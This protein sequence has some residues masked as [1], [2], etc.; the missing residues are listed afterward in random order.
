MAHTFALLGFDPR[1]PFAAFTHSSELVYLPFL[2]P[3]LAVIAIARL[4]SRASGPAPLTPA[5][6]RS[7]R[8]DL[9]MFVLNGA[10]LFHILAAGVVAAPIVG[11]TRDHL[12]PIIGTHQ[13]LHGVWAKICITLLITLVIDFSFFA[14][15]VL[16]HRVP[17]LWCFHKVHHSAPV[18]TPFTAYR[19]HPVD[20]LTEG[21]IVSVLLGV[22]DGVL[23]L[24]LDPT[25]SLVTIAGTNAVFLIGLAG[26]A[27][28]RHS[29]VW[30]SWGH[31][32][33]HVLCSPAQHQIH[34]S[35][36]PRHHDRNFGGL[37]SLWD[38]LFG[39]LITARTREDHL[40]PRNRVGTLSHG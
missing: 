28:L 33:E 25:I 36:D 20:D 6:K 9:A 24:L 38:W 17:V 40:R 18:M 39:T 8:N 21:A 7:I 4:R 23:L 10:F 31:R 29:H 22:F 16:Q 11:W 1:Q 37:L 27:N 30:I 26:F 34:H 15:H 13:L 12:R 2:L 5:A 32:L 3:A 35:T 14:A 19:S